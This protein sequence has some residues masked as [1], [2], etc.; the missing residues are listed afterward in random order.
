[1]TVEEMECDDD[2]EDE[3]V[4]IWKIDEPSSLTIENLMSSCFKKLAE[5]VGEEESKTICFDIIFNEDECFRIDSLKMTNFQLNNLLKRANIKLPKKRAIKRKKTELSV[6]VNNPAVNVE[7][8]ESATS[9]KN[10]QTSCQVRKP[11][12]GLGVLFKSRKLQNEFYKRSSDFLKER[13]LNIKMTLSSLDKTSPCDSF[14]HFLPAKPGSFD[15]LSTLMMSTLMTTILADIVTKEPEN[16][17]DPE[18]IAAN[19]YDLIL[20]MNNAIGRENGQNPIDG[21]NLNNILSVQKSA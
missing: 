19:T 9:S 8:D 13:A 5:R 21:F 16:F 11:L 7:P 4:K 10:A 17:L 15:K 1:M 6:S 12:S 14:C 3:W 2:D 18:K 20:L